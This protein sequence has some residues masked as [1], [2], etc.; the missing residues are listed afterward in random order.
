MLFGCLLRSPPS[1]PFCLFQFWLFPNPCK[2]HSL[3]KI[4]T[5]GFLCFGSLCFF[6]FSKQNLNG[7]PHGENMLVYPLENAQ[8][9]HF[10]QDGDLGHTLLLFEIG[11]NL[12]IFP[13]IDTT[14]C[15]THLSISCF[16][17]S[18]KSVLFL[19]TNMSAVAQT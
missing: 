13:T 12:F 16:P 1:I 5:C 9:F 2:D 17:I 4:S 7:F 11:F 10:I 19:I 15:R 14:V 8:R 18:P 6:V 3:S